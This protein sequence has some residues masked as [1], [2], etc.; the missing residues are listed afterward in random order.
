MEAEEPEGR[1]KGPEER[2]IRR[3]DKFDGTGSWSDRVFTLK[4]A[5]CSGDRGLVE[6]MDWVEQKDVITKQILGDDLSDTDVDPN[7]SELFDVLVG[8]TAGA[9]HHGGERRREH[10]RAL[11]VEQTLREVQPGHAS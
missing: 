3:A 7:A 11:G 1:K 5:A 4:A 8:L 9:G 10:E 2:Q 6:T